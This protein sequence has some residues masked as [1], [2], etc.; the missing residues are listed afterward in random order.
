MSPKGAIEIRKAD[1]A[2]SK[3]NLCD[4]SI[5]MIVRLCEAANWDG[6]TRPK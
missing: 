6:L 2:H 4:L 5:L 3:G 1:K